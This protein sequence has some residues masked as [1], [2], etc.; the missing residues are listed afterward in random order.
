[1][2]YSPRSEHH[3]ANL[4]TTTYL[5]PAV[6]AI[7]PALEQRHTDPNGFAAKLSSDIAFAQSLTD[8]PLPDLMSVFGPDPACAVA[9]VI[10]TGGLDDLVTADDRDWAV[11]QLINAAG[12][13]APFE[14]RDSSDDQAASRAAARALATAYALGAITSRDDDI[15]GALHRLAAHPVLEVRRTLVINLGAIWSAPC[16]TTSSGR[17]LHHDAA[18]V[19]PGLIRDAVIPEPGQKIAAP[20]NA[21]A[22]FSQR[23]GAKPGARVLG[24]AA[25]AA[26]DAETG[27]RCPEL[28]NEL[29]TAAYALLDAFLAALTDGRADWHAAHMVAAAAA[30]HDAQ[31]GQLNLIRDVSSQLVTAGPLPSWHSGV[32]NAVTRDPSLAVVIGG[33]WVALMA[34][35]L[36]QVSPGTPALAQDEADIRRTNLAALLPPAGGGWPTPADLGGVLPAWLLAATANEN[37]I[38]RFCL[39][40]ASSALPAGEALDA[41]GILITDA[42]IAAKL[43]HLTDLFDYLQTVTLSA[44]DERRMHIWTDTFVKAGDSRFARFQSY[45]T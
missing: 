25:A 33:G 24:P 9:A 13:L 26:L 11:T 4:Q 27:C 22:E 6:Q 29:H 21:I 3:P 32:F 16:R 37:A 17:C 8:D 1:M 43:S 5:T 19:L 41:L 14:Y 45:L 20:R 15:L 44:E 38:D 10:L 36:P 42:A 28:G 30:R 39:W 34:D 23:T 31:S 12:K 35:L 18:D 40:A 7:I 2:N